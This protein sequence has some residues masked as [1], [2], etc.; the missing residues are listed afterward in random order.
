MNLTAIAAKF[1]PQIKFSRRYFLNTQPLNSSKFFDEV[2]HIG[3]VYHLIFPFRRII[4]LDMDLKFRV[5]VAE[6]WQQFEFM[7]DDNII[8]VAND[9]APHYWW[10]FRHF[11]RSHPDTK[12]GQCRPG[13][14]AGFIS[15]RPFPLFLK[16]Y[17]K[18]CFAFLRP[19]QGFNTGVLLLD[20]D[21]IRRN[22]LYRSYLFDENASLQSLL[23]KYE[24]NGTLAYQ[25]FFTLIGMEHPQLF[26]QMDC[27]WN[28]Q[29]DET[30]SVDEKLNEMFLACHRCDQRV[31]IYHAN[32]GSD[33]PEDDENDQ[34]NFDPSSDAILQV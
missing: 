6:L 2:F 13:L 30:S 8:A 22:R 7:E 15:T 31:Q 20:L 10:D 5:D 17:V 26:R 14:Q 21:R 11:R 33:M 4:A 32:G 19:P 18:E 3:L 9:L 28:R 24:F 25:D 23:T 34:H 1:E 27:S 12:V 29:L 16:N